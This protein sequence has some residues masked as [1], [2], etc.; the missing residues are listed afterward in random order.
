MAT[1]PKK[2]AVKRASQPKRKPRRKAASPRGRQAG[3]GAFGKYFLPGAISACILIC[4]GVLMFFGYR[5]VTASNFFEVRDVAVAGTTRASKQDIERIVRGETEKLG[6]W[7]A[8][9]PDIRQ[10]IEKLPYIKSAAVSRA[11]PNGMRVVVTERIP[12]AVVHLSAGD[13][14]VDGEAEIL[15][16]IDKNNPPQDLMI[17]RGWDEAKSERAAKDN[18]ARIKMFQKMTSDWG[19]FGLG[20]KVKE[21]NLSDLLEPK[22]V[23]E[24]SGS[25]IPVTLSREEF[26]KSLKSAIE[27]VAGKG[28]RIKSVNSSG[29]YP[30]IEYIGN[31]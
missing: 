19:E 26:A 9:L 17:I 3:T 15:A 4:L 25:Q 13:Y 21:V 5:T 22:A 30:V 12:I 8:D 20:K 2:K 6:A 28:E 16:P 14:F 11:L 10:K 31:N 27:A 24:D 29:V 7:N 1:Q 23:V 18:S